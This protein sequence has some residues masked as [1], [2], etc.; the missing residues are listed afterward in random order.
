M[1]RRPPGC[2]SAARERDL[3]VAAEERLGPTDPAAHRPP[4]PIADRLGVGE[5]AGCPHVD[6]PR[7]LQVGAAHDRDA[8]RHLVV[9]DRGDVIIAEVAAAKRVLQLVH[10]FQVCVARDRVQVREVGGEVGERRAGQERREHERDVV[11]DLVHVEGDGPEVAHGELAG[12]PDGLVAQPNEQ[13]DPGHGEPHGGAQHE[14][15]VL[16]ADAL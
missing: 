3:P 14:Q 13:D 10:P 6:I 8:V 9:R 16:D 1:E 4:L 15:D 12:A 11:R 5:P 7:L 2:P